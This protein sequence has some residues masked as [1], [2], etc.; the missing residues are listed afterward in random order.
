MLN[1]IE[2]NMSELNSTNFNLNPIEKSIQPKAVSSEKA[3]QECKAEETISDI[4]TNH[5]EIIGRSML[6]NDTM[7]NDL[8]TLLKNPQVAENSDKLF[9]FAYAQATTQGLD[10]VYEEAATFSTTQL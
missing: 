7:K 1:S 10:N 5:A 2:V 8:D 6:A 4:T 3:P 9:E